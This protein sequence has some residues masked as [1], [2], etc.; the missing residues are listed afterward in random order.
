MT[1][2]PPLPDFPREALGMA[3]K[4]RTLRIQVHAS[5]EIDSHERGE[6]VEQAV[7][8]AIAHLGAL[9]STTYKFE[10]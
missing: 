3:F 6:A 1:V 4:K 7:A 5:F 2:I 8:A 10:C 9:G